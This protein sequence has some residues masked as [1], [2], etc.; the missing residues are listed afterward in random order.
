MTRW[1][2]ISEDLIRVG[3]WLLALEWSN[4]LFGLPS[5]LIGLEVCLVVLAWRL[6]LWPFGA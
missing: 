1:V 2:Q 4:Y 6:R 3:A 5:T